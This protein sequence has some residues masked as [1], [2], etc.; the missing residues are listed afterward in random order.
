VSEGSG[1]HPSWKF[2]GRLGVVRGVEAAIV[3]DEPGEHG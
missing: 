1:E 3:A 2:V